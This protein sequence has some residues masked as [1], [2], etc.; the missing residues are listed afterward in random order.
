MVVP[1]IQVRVLTRA[2][3]MVDRRTV[4][5]NP[6]K[7]GSTCGRCGHHHATG[8]STLGCYSSWLSDAQRTNPEVVATLQ[9]L[10]N[11]LVETGE[12]QIGCHCT[13]RVLRS[14]SDLPRCCHAEV[15]GWRL[16]RRWALDH[17]PKVAVVGSRTFGDKVL[18]SQEVGK[19][20]PSLIVS[21]GARGADS[22]AEEWALRFRIPTRIY[23]AEWDK[24][25][26][27]AGFRRNRDIVDGCEVLLAFWDGESRGTA[28]S[29]KLAES[30]GK[31]VRVIK[32]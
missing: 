14:L 26:R 25:G 9:G 6:Y 4:L 22:L 18:L 31:V 30:A 15:I 3:I 12:L 23:P 19:L 32:F 27:S 24:Y 8:A 11:R 2:G 28:H 21:G 29:I 7:V 20:L 16:L 5:G 1:V 17:G 13:D 10:Y